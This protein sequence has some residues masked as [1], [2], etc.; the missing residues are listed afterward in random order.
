MDQDFWAQSPPGAEGTRE[1]VFL[2]HWLTEAGNSSAFQRIADGRP[3][4][5][6]EEHA[7]LLEALHA[8]ALAYQQLVRDGLPRRMPV[9]ENSSLVPVVIHLIRG[10]YPIEDV[11]ESFRVLAAWEAEAT[12]EDSLDVLDSLRIWNCPHTPC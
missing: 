9:A 7:R 12:H 4:L 3:P 6:S 2:A 5:R 8:D 1:A 11:L 10:W